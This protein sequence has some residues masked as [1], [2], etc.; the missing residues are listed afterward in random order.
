M[1]RVVLPTG[2]DCVCGARLRVHTPRTYVCDTCG[3]KY[4]EENGC[5]VTELAE[6]VCPI[7]EEW[8]PECEKLLKVSHISQPIG[9]FIE[10]LLGE[11]GYVLAEWKK[12][13]DEDDELFPVHPDITRLLAEFFQVDLNR[14]EDERQ[15]IMRALRAQQGKEKVPDGYD[16]IGGGGGSARSDLPAGQRGED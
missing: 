13:D 8:M 14:V 1:T 10:W 4:R 2:S 7:R 9:E 3:R 12:N 16:P 6:V 15:A 11:R 5:L